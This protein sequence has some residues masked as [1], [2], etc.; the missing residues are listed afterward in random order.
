MDCVKRAPR[1]WSIP[2]RPAPLFGEAGIEGFDVLTEVDGALGLSLFRALRDIQAWGESP[3]ESRD[4]LFGDP[5]LVQQE[6]TASAARQEPAL[7]DALYALSVERPFV[8]ARRL[9]ACYAVSAWAEETG[10]YQ[11][12]LLFAEA[13][14]WLD[15]TSAVAANLAGRL[16]RASARWERSKDWLQRAYLLSVRHR[17]R[18]TAVQALVSYAALM[19]DRGRLS[20]AKKFLR[21]AARKVVRQRLAAEYQ[22]DFVCLGIESGDYEGAFT[23]V[24]STINAYS[25]S[26]PRLPALGYDFSYLLI[27]H[28]NYEP[29]KAVLEQTLPLMVQPG[30]RG[31]VSAAFARVAAGLG[32]V[33]LSR[34]LEDAAADLAKAH[35]TFGGAIFIH[36]GE[37]ARHRRRFPESR[38]YAGQALDA[39]TERQDPLVRRLAEVLESQARRNEAPPSPCET[40]VSV[41]STTRHLLFKLR[42]WR[43][44]PITPSPAITD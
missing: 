35:P 16:C 7:S 2:P 4:H 43:G 5:S 9:Q 33:E 21:K 40:P 41:W 37:A 30:E 29:A 1:L 15:P 3:R 42:R 25:L 32:M 19:K 38:F 17:N 28:G 14:T 20:E 24:R 31:V 23:A 8:V 6:R 18:E 11:T 13:A 26:H 12:A 27:L 36:L 22:H 10:R 34:Q 44:R 39:A